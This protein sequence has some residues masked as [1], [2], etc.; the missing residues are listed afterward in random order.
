MSPIYAVLAGPLCRMSHTRLVLWY[1]HWRKTR[2]LRIAEQLSNVVLSVDRRSFPFP[3]AK[4]IATGHGI[5]L[6]EFPCTEHPRSERLRLL[7]LGRYSRAKGIDTVIRGWHGS[8][9][10]A[11]PARADA[12]ARRAALPPRARRTSDRA[13]RRPESDTLR[14]RA[15]PRGTATLR[16]RMRWSTTCEP[17]RRTRSYTRR[18]RRA[19][20]P[21]VEPRVRPAAP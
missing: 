6:D 21:G 20:R 2:L 19:S 4:V 18:P 11:D 16:G 8:E 1:T 17:V 7:S 14:T 15:A 5:D 10:R 9:R 3:S 12:H 13:R